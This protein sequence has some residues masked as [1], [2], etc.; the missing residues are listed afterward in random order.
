MGCWKEWYASTK[1]TRHVIVVSKCISHCQYCDNSSPARLQTDQ[2]ELPQ[3]RHHHLVWRWRW[4]SSSS[5][6]GVKKIITLSHFIRLSIVFK[7]PLWALIL[8]HFW[9]SIYIC[10]IWDTARVLRCNVHCAVSHGPKLN[11]S[12]SLQWVEFT[13]SLTIELHP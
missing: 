10:S 1:N 4:R 13:P 3:T 7:V 12:Q 8:F 6:G 11:I 2:W 5:C 9:Y